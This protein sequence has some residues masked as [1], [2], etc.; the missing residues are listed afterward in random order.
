MKASLFSFVLLF[1]ASAAVGQPLPPATIARID[2]VFAPYAETDRPG[3]AL[4]ISQQGS[5]VYA[6]GYGM[7]DLQYGLAITPGS[8]FHV[9]SVSK[10]FAAF[11]IAL[12]AEDGK[13]SLDDPVSKHVPELPDWS[14]SI[15]I[16]QLI[17]HTSGVR[18]QWE[19]LGMAGWRYGHDLFTQDDVLEILKRQ[20]GL[21]FAPGDEW[22]YSNSGYSLIA[23]IVQRVSGKTLRQFSEER[24]FKPLGMTST[25]VHD[26]HQMIVPNRT[27]AY[28]TGPGGE[29]RISIP[30][31]DTH[32]ATSLFT[33]VGDLLKWE[34][35]FVTGTVGS[36]ALLAE[37]ER[38]AKLNNGKDTDYGFGIQLE[39]Y[40]GVPARGHGGADAGYRA[41]VVR[42]PDQGLAIATLCNFAS[43]S[44]NVYSRRVADILLEG[45]LG[46][47]TETVAA[48]AGA[49]ASEAELKSVA[50][51]YRKP[52]ADAAWALVIK[53]GG[54]F[55]DAFGVPLSPLGNRRFSVSF[56]LLVEFFGP[57]D[58]P[59]TSVKASY[60]GQVL[61]SLVRVKEF[62][63]TR[64]QLAAFAGDYY[65]DEL[66]VVY[67]VTVQD[68]VL[69]LRRPKQGEVRMRPLYED[70]FSAEGTVVRFIRKQARVEGFVVSGGR[71]RGVTFT[72][73][74]PRPNRP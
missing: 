62:I 53:D 19:L 17:Y 41:D 40:R 55:L 70:A 9:A 45:K 63:P 58:G 39:T 68:S 69:A 44:P 15:T 7:S 31:F 72:R 23:M 60:Q 16:R 6:K 20:H 34:Q 22:V 50:G 54:L 71:V 12:L 33:T 49:K 1:G 35:N 13:L 24:I 25:H 59:A 47:K 21:N 26:D 3:C 36:R 65:S 11:A 48:P 27:S 51:V 2:S 64:Q 67:S 4:G 73:G 37:A 32:G 42:F 61:D 14:K 57:A 46:P 52:G 5:Q 43:A 29:W 38:S 10:Q 74:D 66:G 30:T 56:G 8:I 28:E 18:D